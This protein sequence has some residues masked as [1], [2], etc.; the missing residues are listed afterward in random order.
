MSAVRQT[1]RGSVAQWLW[2]LV[3]LSIIGIPAVIVFAIGVWFLL[4]VAR[5]VLT[6]VLVLV[7]A[8]SILLSATRRSPPARR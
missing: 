3:G 8:A 2:L 4:F 1:T 7:A 5:L 6:I